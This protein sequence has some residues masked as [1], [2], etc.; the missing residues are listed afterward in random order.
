MISLSTHCITPVVHH[1]TNAPVVFIQKDNVINN[2]NLDQSMGVKKLAIFLILVVS[3]IGQD[4]VDERTVSENVLDVED[5]GV[6]DKDI[7]P[8]K[9]VIEDPIID[10]AAAEVLT[11]TE[12]LQVRSGKYQLNDG[13]VGEEPVNLESVDFNSNILESEKQVLMPGPTTTLQTNTEYG[14]NYL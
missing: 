14:K 9:D 2:R 8:D 11:E 10:E 5:V 4:A 12:G 13:L 1:N 6:S 7:V 3:V